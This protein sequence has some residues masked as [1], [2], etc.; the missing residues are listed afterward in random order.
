LYKRF[1]DDGKAW[2]LWEAVTDGADAETSLEADGE[3]D[4]NHDEAS[5]SS[6]REEGS[7][8]A[9]ADLNADSAAILAEALSEAEEK[10]EA[11]RNVEGGVDERQEEEEAMHSRHDSR[12]REMASAYAAAID[13]GKESE[14]CEED[15]EE[16]SE[17][18]GNGSLSPVNDDD[19][20]VVHESE[21]DVDEAA[22]QFEDDVGDSSDSVD[23]DASIEAEA[24][25]FEESRVIY[26]EDERAQHPGQ[27]SPSGNVY[28]VQPLPASPNGSTESDDIVYAECD[29]EGVHEGSGGGSPSTSGAAFVLVRRSGGAVFDARAWRERHVAR[30]QLVARVRE[31]KQEKD[32]ALQRMDE[33]A[34]RAEVEAAALAQD[35]YSRGSNGRPNRSSSRTRS[36]G[37]GG[38]GGGGISNADKKRPR[39][40]SPDSSSSSHHFAAHPAAATT[41]APSTAATAATTTSAL[42]SAGT[43]ILHALRRGVPQP[44]EFSA[45]HQHERAYTA[46]SHARNAG[47]VEPQPAHTGDAAS[48]LASVQS[49]ELMERRRRERQHRRAARARQAAANAAAS[50]D[51]DT[52]GKENAANGSFEAGSKAEARAGPRKRGMARWFS[53]S[54]LSSGAPANSTAKSRAASKQAVSGAVAWELEK[55]DL[56]R[57]LT[58]RERALVL[59]FSDRTNF[60]A[61]VA[62]IARMRDTSGSATAN[63]SARPGQE[64]DPMPGSPTRLRNGGVRV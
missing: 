47:H 29:A 6:H 25:I 48:F 33:Q 39:N 64:A 50:E 14:E 30:S 2:T 21:E 53:S 49:P 1:G 35:Y 9:A 19:E 3:E 34:A 12:M 10:E 58:P 46:A 54:S 52:E 59:T 41:P 7:E 57:D 13:E 55:A 32:R 61:A 4:A 24:E 60:R 36:N 38:Y 8:Q 22:A 62:A 11:L 51:G 44:L 45:N 37:G 15:G 5:L 43:R 63:S 40:P 42:G 26:S 28:K 56:L 27:Q 16:A 18:E 31:R 23:D 17:S 20:S